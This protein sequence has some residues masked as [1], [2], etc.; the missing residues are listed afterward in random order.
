MRLISALHGGNEGDCPCGGM[1]STTVLT[2]DMGKTPAYTQGSSRTPRSAPIAPPHPQDRFVDDQFTTADAQMSKV[3]SGILD[4]VAFG[5]SVCRPPT[6]HHISTVPSI[7]H[8]NNVAISPAPQTPRLRDAAA[9]PLARLD[10]CLRRPAQP[11]RAGAWRRRCAEV[12]RCAAWQ[13][14]ETTATGVVG[15]EAIRMNREGEIVTPVVPVLT[16]MADVGRPVR[17]GGCARAGRRALARQPR[18]HVVRS[19][20]SE[21]RHGEIGNAGGHCDAAHTVTG[22]TLRATAGVC[23]CLWSARTRIL[24]AICTRICVATCRL[25]PPC[26]S[27]HTLQSQPCP[28]L[29]RKPSWLLLPTSKHA[30]F[31]SPTHTTK[32]PRSRA[33]TSSSTPAT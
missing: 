22:S 10:A 31:S 18:L 27:S 3:P 17:R 30:S 11:W 26:C 6:H 7:S 21:S 12:R 32:H 20:G 25:S 1:N 28:H 2:I 19:G 8:P 15:P 13:V 5:P 24:V 16:D 29:P 33:A 14:R 23:F 9:H 4:H